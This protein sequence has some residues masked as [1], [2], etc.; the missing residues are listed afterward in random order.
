MAWF[1]S[2]LLVLSV[3]SASGL[4]PQ[5]FEWRFPPADVSWVRRVTPAIFSSGRPDRNEISLIREVGFASLVSVFALDATSVWNNITGDFVS[6]SDYDQIGKGLGLATRVF[7]FSS[8]TA[9]ESF[10]AFASAMDILPKPILV[11]CHVGYA[12]TTFATLYAIRTGAVPADEFYSRTLQQGFEYQTNPG[13]NSLWADVAQAKEVPATVESVENLRLTGGDD[14]YTTYYHTKRLTDDWYVAGQPNITTELASVKAS[15]YG[16][17]VN[18]RVDGEEDANWPGGH[19][20]AAAE[21]RAMEAA[22]ISYFT[23]P[24][25][26]PITAAQLRNVREK[27]AQAAATVPI[28]SAGPVLVHCKSGFRATASVL[29]LVGAQE[30]RNWQWALR[31][32]ESIGFSFWDSEAS[33]S[34]AQ[35]LTQVLPD[36]SPIHIV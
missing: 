8:W 7:N 35:A 20:V 1:A 28:G 6:T 32:A 16:A 10:D 5:K 33:E 11:H 4:A 26:D 29:A 15:G 2:A 13:V 9:P 31:Q 17:V 23:V 3:S 19:Y 24:V 21:K 25:S 30:K 12:A 14:G 27:L 18:L 22:G 34:V 36:S